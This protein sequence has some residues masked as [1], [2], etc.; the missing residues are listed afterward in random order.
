MTQQMHKIRRA[1]RQ[2][3]LSASWNFLE[4]EDVIR[5][6]VC[7]D[8]LPYIIPVNFVLYE[9][10][11]CFHS[12]LEGRKVNLFNTEA[13]VF[14]EADKMI[15]VKESKRGCSFSC[16]YQSLMITGV[17]RKVLE[18]E[19]K[20]SILNALVEKYATEEFSK[21]TVDDSK[22]VLVYCI[23]VKDITGKELL[24]DN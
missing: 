1:E 23:K 2:M 11:I 24:P 7:D 13:E 20:V 19:E 17:L 16:Y 3:S 10:M 22:R 18:E 14:V 12:A 15:R 8:N 21:V 4:K 6:G 9:G 5:I